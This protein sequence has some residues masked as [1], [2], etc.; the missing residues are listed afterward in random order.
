[1]PSTPGGLPYPNSSDP[2]ANGAQDIQDLAEAVDSGLGLWKIASGTVTL[3]TTPTQI[4][5]VFSS[6]FR[7]YRLILNTTSRSTSNRFDMRYL[8][9]TT[10]TT[11]NYY[12]GG[13]AS[14]WATNATIYMQRSANDPT[15]FGVAG[16][17][18]EQQNAIIDVIAP[19]LAAPTL[20]SGQLAS[21]TSAYAFSF[22]G[23]QAGNGAFTGFQLTTNAG[24]ITMNYQVFG[25]RD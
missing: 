14:D 21:R 23:L 6:A 25:Y 1:M 17:T 20:H 2:V 9:G 16:S 22:G 15:F 8:V 19:N 11:V 13:I 10:E 7:N 4:T 18:G 5:G 24:T 12:Q 3:S